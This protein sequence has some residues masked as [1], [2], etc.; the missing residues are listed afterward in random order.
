[1]KKLGYAPQNLH[2]RDIASLIYPH[3]VS[4]PS[5]NRGHGLHEQKYITR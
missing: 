4:A 2:M 1:M 3:F 5:F